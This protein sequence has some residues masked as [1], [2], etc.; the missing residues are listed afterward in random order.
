MKVKRMRKER[1][2]GPRGFS[3]WVQPQMGKYFLAC[4]DCG[5][6]HETQFRITPGAV[7]G[8]NAGQSMHV[9]FRMR[10]ADAYTR[11]ERKKMGIVVR[12]TPPA[13]QE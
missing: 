5:L 3:R 12:T 10:R 11:R 7:R 9:Q 1:A 8:V 4:C 13:P 6:V 2:V